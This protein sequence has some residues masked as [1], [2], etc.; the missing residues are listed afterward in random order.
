MKTGDE[1]VFSELFHAV[2]R[3][4]VATTVCIGARITKDTLLEDNA[5]LLKNPSSEPDKT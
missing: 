1:N 5:K 4:T 3:P 2:I